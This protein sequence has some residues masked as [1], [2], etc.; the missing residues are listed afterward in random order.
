MIETD[1]GIIISVNDWHR[2]NARY[3]INVTDEGIIICS[4]DKHAKN[5]QLMFEYLDL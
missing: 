1:D 3:L 4:N 5:E 2:S